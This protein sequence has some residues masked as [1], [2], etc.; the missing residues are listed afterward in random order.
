MGGRASASGQA[1]PRSEDEAVGRSSAKSVTLNEKRKDNRVVAGYSVSD[2]PRPPIE[3]HADHRSHSSGQVD[4]SPGVLILVERRE[5]IRGC[6]TC[7]LD[8]HCSEIAAMPVADVESALRPDLLSRSVAAVIGMEAS[9]QHDW[10]YSQVAWLRAR[11][12]R[13]PIILVVESDQTQAASDLA[14]QLDLQGYIP[15]FSSLEVA[16]AAVHLVVA[17][18]S[19]FPRPHSEEPRRREL[20]L[21]REELAAGRVRIAEL[22]ARERAVLGL[23]GSG[24][25][26]KVIAH[27]L[28]MSLSTVKAHVH[29]IIRKLK[30]GNRTEVALLVQHLYPG[31]TE[32][33][34][35]GAPPIAMALDPRSAICATMADAEASVDSRGEDSP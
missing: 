1:L 14:A 25:P 31:T 10:L 35:A 3:W 20:L 18:G 9:E 5:F 26:N 13:L 34:D 6:L 28:G 29:H 22:T 17:G 24:M 15:T 4:V 11:H 23:L 8:K 12:T 19:Y 16:A 27:R 33:S 7:W 30:V 21:G 32:I 2:H